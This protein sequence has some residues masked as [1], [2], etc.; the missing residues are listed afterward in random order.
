[1]RVPWMSSCPSFRGEQFTTNLSSPRFSNPLIRW[2]FNW[3]LIKGN[4]FLSLVQRQLLAA[5]RPSRQKANKRHQYLFI[6]NPWVWVQPQNFFSWFLLWF[7]YHMW[8]KSPVNSWNIFSFP[9]WKA[10]DLAEDRI[11]SRVSSLLEAKQFPFIY[12]LPAFHGNSYIGRFGPQLCL[13]EH[14]IYWVLL[15]FLWVYFILFLH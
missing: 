13:L 3:S 8:L 14:S 6:L 2:G 4:H 12:S 1:M 7:L 9:M 15:G 11:Y 10:G 5:P